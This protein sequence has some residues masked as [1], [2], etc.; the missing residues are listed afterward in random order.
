MY[1]HNNGPTFRNAR[2]RH[3][4]VWKTY[5]YTYRRALTWSLKCDNQMI[6]ALVQM[7]NEHYAAR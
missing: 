3:G 4:T 1:T 2:T 7:K 5:V 6:I